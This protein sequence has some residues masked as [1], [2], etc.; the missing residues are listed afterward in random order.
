MK[1]RRGGQGGGG[2]ARL[3]RHP[4]PYS[5]IA[6]CRSCSHI[7]GHG[8]APLAVTSWAGLP[9]FGCSEEF[10]VD[11]GLHSDLCP[12]STTP[13]GT[14]QVTPRTSEP[15]R[16]V[17]VGWLTRR[18]IKWWYIFVFQDKLSCVCSSWLFLSLVKADPRTRL[19]LYPPPPPPKEHKPPRDMEIQIESSQPHWNICS[20]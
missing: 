14:G 5:L 16:P 6:P 9:Y 1:G 18:A 15:R 19:W 13:P 8:E 7:K 4:R 11:R 17:C 12:A 3:V 20:Q 2:L 10:C